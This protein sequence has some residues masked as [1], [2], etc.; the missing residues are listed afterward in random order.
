MRTRLRCF[1]FLAVFTWCALLCLAQQPASDLRQDIKDFVETPAIPG[2]EGDLAGKIAD[3]LHTYNPKIDELGDVVLT[4]GSGAPHRLMV[5]PMDEPAYVVSEITRDGYLRLQRLPQGGAL[6]RFNELYAAQPVKTQTTQGKWIDGV[7]AG[8]SVHL[9]PARQHAPDLDDIDNMY[10]DIGATSDTEVRAA[11]VDLLSPLA[12]N[13]T[14][15]EMGQGYWTAPAVSD[16]FGDAALVE[17]LRNLDRGKLTG[18]LTVAF[19]AQQWTGARGLQRVLDATKPDEVINVGPLVR[20]A[21]ANAGAPSREPGSGV[22]IGVQD[23]NAALTAFAK[24]MKDVATKNSISINPDFSAPLLPKSYLPQ[25]PLPARTVHLAV[26]TAWA[27]TPAEVIDGNDVAALVS[28]LTAY[29]GGQSRAERFVSPAALPTALPPARPHTSPNLQVVLQDLVET[30]GVSGHEAAVHEAVSRLL[31]SWAKTETEAGN[32]ILHWGSNARGPSILVVAH[33]DEIGFVVHSLLPD[34]RLELETKGGG[35]ASYFLGHAALVHTGSGMRPGVIELTAGWDK[36]GFKWPD[37]RT[38]MFHMDVGARNPQEVEQLGIKTGDFV[39][40]PKKYRPLL[41]TR[42]NGRSFDDRVGCTALV[43]AT[44]AL[45]PDLKNRDVTFVWS[46]GEEVGLEGAAEVAK[47]L[48]AQGKAPDY[49]F[50]VDTFVSSDSPLES[51]RFADALVGHG[52][53][54]RAVDNSNIV[55]RKLVEKILALAKAAGIPAQYGVTGGGNDGAAFLRYG[56]TDVALGWP[57]RYSHSAAEVVDT[58]DVDALAR[59]VAAVARQW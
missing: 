49:V 35:E 6:P 26:G 8:L 40:I 3:R 20:A 51:K 2:Y 13:R 59:I 39:T 9:Q 57:L 46:T 43:L 36:P 53:V 34:G 30:Y 29:L 21:G 27:N 50:A 7:V 25:P 28:M 58:R 55:P 38:T 10:V 16:R 47:S 11:G 4:I 14:F 54:V 42:A 19:V 48:A 15:Y 17:V 1:V 56:S 37:D 52:F 5:A 22:L 41:G 45:G 44:W 32:I 33:Q 24:E 31:P 12:I 23:P 18:T